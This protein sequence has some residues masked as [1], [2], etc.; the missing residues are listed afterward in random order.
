MRPPVAPSAG[1]PAVP[2]VVE[3]V[4][5][6][7]PLDVDPEELAAPADSDVL[8]G[9]TS[10]KINL[11]DVPPRGTDH[12]A[13]VCPSGPALRQQRRRICAA[14]PIRL[15]AGSLPAHG[16]RPS[17][18]PVHSLC[19]RIDHSSGV[20]VHPGA[21]CPG[22][23][24]PA[25]VLRF[26]WN[27]VARPALPVWARFSQACALRG[28]VLCPI[29]NWRRGRAPVRPRLRHP[30]PI[31]QRRCRLPVRGTFRDV[32][33]V[34]TRNALARPALPRWVTWAALIG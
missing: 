18:H 34:P 3:P 17:P 11:F 33:F 28:L 23:W 19:S 29:S 10:R 9:Q 32:Q 27:I 14:S 16:S 13:R 4:G 7:P 8:H 20:A 6:P 15:Q 24:T 12:P 26:P 1:L 21:A 25:G 5:G 22:R 2:T 30:P 31:R